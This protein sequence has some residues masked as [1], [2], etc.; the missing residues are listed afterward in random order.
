MSRKLKGKF[1]QKGL[2]LIEASMVLVLSAV[3]VAGVMTYYET[4][5]NNNKLDK[6]TSEIMHIVSEVNG[7]YANAERTAAGSNYTGLTTDSILAAVNDTEK[8]EVKDSQGNK[9][10]VIK[11]PFDDA[12]IVIGAARKKMLGGYEMNPKKQANRFM[13]QIA[14]VNVAACTKLMSIN[15][16]P[17]LEAIQVFR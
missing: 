11:T 13:I 1:H 9:I 10:I 2:S 3:V 15:Y 12:V 5:Q 17:Q 4:A 14:G 7:L 8:G 16:G 6:L